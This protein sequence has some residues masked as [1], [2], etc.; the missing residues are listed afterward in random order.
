V[1]LTQDIPF[2]SQDSTWESWNGAMLHYFGEEPLPIVAEPD[3]Q[4]FA[5]AMVGLPT[6]SVYGISDGQGILDWREWASQVIGM[7]N[8]ATQ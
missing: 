7:V 3:W 1:A 8:G 4:Q 2:L 6:F 5:A